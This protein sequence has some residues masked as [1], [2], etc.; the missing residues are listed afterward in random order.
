MVQGVD[1]EFKHQYRKNKSLYWV[2]IQQLPSCCCG[3]WLLMAPV[4]LRRLSHLHILYGFY[5]M[6]YIASEHR[7][8][9]YG[10]GYTHNHEVIGPVAL[11]PDP[12]AARFTVMEKLLKLPSWR[13]YRTSRMY[14]KTMATS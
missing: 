9:R 11:A 3:C 1:L 13:Q 4:L 7:R 14:L 12:V 5:G 10:N 6:T 8:S 2:I